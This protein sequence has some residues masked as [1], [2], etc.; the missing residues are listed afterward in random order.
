M[1]LAYKNIKRVRMIAKDGIPYTWFVILKGINNTRHYVNY[2]PEGRT[3]T[4][5]YKLDRLPKAVQKF[6]KTAPEE[7]ESITEWNGSEVQ[8]FS[9]KLDTSF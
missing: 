1:R 8:H 7:L 2:G 4:D 9:Y 5:E 3:T 6:V